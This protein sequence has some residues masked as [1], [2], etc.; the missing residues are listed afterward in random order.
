MFRAKDHT[1]FPNNCFE[2]F[3][4]FRIALELFWIF[5]E[6]FRS[7]GFK[8]VTYIKLSKQRLTPISKVFNLRAQMLL[9]LRIDEKR[10]KQ[11]L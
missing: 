8:M 11:N 2:K 3:K 6:K 1:H 4:H 10:H 9:F 7:G 5:F